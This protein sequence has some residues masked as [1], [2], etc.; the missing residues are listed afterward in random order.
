MFIIISIFL[1][2]AFCFLVC[3]P[4]LRTTIAHFFSSLGSSFGWKRQSGP[5][6]PPEHHR[7]SPPRDLAVPEHEQHRRGERHPTPEVDSRQGE[8]PVTELDSAHD[9]ESN[10]NHSPTV[11]RSSSPRS[12]GVCPEYQEDRMNL[13]IIWPSQN[14][15]F[16]SHRSRTEPETSE[17]REELSDDE[18]SQKLH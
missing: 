15:T 11:G 2:A 3:V 8:A 12:G 17:I 4:R 1:T 18:P 16:P 5:G 10:A 14:C 9:M 13:S 6:E 7:E